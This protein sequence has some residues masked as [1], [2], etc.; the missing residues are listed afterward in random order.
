MV[1]EVFMA[2][3]RCLRQRDRRTP[4]LVRLALKWLELG[5]Y[6]ALPT[7]KDGGFAMV[8]KEALCAELLRCLDGSQYVRD[9]RGHMHA[10]DLLHEYISLSKRI[11]RVSSSDGLKRALLCQVGADSS[12]L[13]FGL[14]ATVKTHKPRGRVQMRVLYTMRRGS[15]IA[16]G[17]RFVASRLTP[18]LNRALTSL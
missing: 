6:T 15:P 8:E 5:R 3:R 16:P 1:D 10:D 18:F 12:S 13:Y 11:A 2:C 9:R 4:E 17:M 7:D 14:A